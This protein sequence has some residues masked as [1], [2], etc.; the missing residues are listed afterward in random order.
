MFTHIPAVLHT[1]ARDRR[2]MGLADLSLAS[3]SV[4]HTV[5]WK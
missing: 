1:G 5:L 3:D 4:R 2:I